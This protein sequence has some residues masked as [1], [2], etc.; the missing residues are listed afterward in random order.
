MCHGTVL[1][2]MRRCIFTVGRCKNSHTLLSNIK[3]YKIIFQCL[4]SHQTIVTRLWLELSCSLYFLYL[5]CKAGSKHSM[6]V[7]G[8]GLENL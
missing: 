7:H 8:N 1:S 3:Y 5:H 6:V 2:L 4:L